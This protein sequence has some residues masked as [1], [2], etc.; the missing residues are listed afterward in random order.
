M[1]A[2]TLDDLKT[3]WQA[4]DRKL[5]RQ[6]TLV[7]H[8][9]K[10]T[11]LMKL[12]GGFRPL[13]RGQVVQTIIG[14]MLALFAGSFWFD[15]IGTPHLMIYG[16]LLHAFGI[17]MMV[18]GIRDLALIH[19]IDCDAPVLEIQKQL[20]ALRSWRL[21][22]AIWF[23][24][25]GCLIWVPGLLILFYLIGADVWVHQPD[26]VF[27]NVASSFVCLGIAYGIIWWSRRPGHERLAKYLQESSVGKSVIRAQKML[28]EI[29]CFERDGGTTVV[30]SQK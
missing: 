16:L 23:A 26:V 11:K 13:V 27:W 19:G 9:F 8:Q 15:H 22:A 5:E 14:L 2:S 18:F 21:R 24:V 20:A 25:A 10:E 28:A 1:T 17:M 3:A 7:L 4:L 12:R 30:S 6:H 29:E